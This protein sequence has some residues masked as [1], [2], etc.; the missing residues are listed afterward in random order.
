MSGKG[1][2]CTQLLFLGSGSS[3]MPVGRRPC[4]LRGKQPERRDL[5]Y[6]K[7]RSCSSAACCAASMLS[8]AHARKEIRSRLRTMVQ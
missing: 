2:L 7:A 4:A 5:P 8:E 6:P 1:A 3:C